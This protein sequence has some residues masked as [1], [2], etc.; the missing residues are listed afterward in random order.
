[1]LGWCLCVVK[2]I[3]CVDCIGWGYVFCGLVI[4]LV[5]FGRLGDGWF[6]VYV[7]VVLFD[8]GIMVFKIF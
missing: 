2:V 4:G 8:E 5:E 6:G 1:M 7:K 3:K